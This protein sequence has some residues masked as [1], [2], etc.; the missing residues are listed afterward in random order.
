MSGVQR[1]QRVREP[2]KQVHSRVFACNSSETH[3]MI[4]ALVKGK[5]IEIDNLDDLS[6][7]VEES[8]IGQ[9]TLVLLDDSDEKF[10][11]PP[12]SKLTAEERR[13]ALLATFGSLKGLVDAEE[14]K[15]QI[16][17]S[18]GQTGRDW[19]FPWATEESE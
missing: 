10:E 15:R 12:A 3:V 18:R 19:T 13:A 2:E 5:R 14:M 7:A 1:R 6:R 9:E 8:R 16:Y 17:K 4:T 11:I